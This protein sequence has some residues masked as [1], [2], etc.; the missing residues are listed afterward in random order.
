MAA[1]CAKERVAAA[2]IARNQH[3]GLDLEAG[4]GPTSER[5]RIR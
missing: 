4:F 5:V 3:C 1:E 2:G